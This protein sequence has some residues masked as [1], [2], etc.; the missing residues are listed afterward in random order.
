[1]PSACSPVSWR[2]G[3]F[4]LQGLLGCEL[5]PDNSS[6]PTAVFALNGEEFMAFD[7][8]IGNWTG[9]WPETELI[10]NLWLKQPE[11]AKMESEFL[12]T[13][14]PQRLLGHLERG[15]QY[16]EWK[17]EPILCLHSGPSCSVQDL[18]KTRSQVA[19]PSQYDLE[20]LTL[21]PSSKCWLSEACCLT[22][23]I[24][25]RPGWP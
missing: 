4:T 13:S 7:P 20:F 19:Q 25:C 10:G 22:Q 15:L 23:L 12:L 2:L 18:F 24:V 3:N 16:L 6:L 9:E 21:P 5:A 8:S 1:M 17:G 11:V 14:C